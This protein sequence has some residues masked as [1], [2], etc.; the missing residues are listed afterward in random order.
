MVQSLLLVVQRRADMLSRLT[1]SL[2]NSLVISNV[3]CACSLW[4][5]RSADTVLLK[6][7]KGEHTVQGPRRQ[8]T[9][10]AASGV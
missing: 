3:K 9:S 1:D 8:T 6:R 4:V 2:S 5:A 7:I 10:R